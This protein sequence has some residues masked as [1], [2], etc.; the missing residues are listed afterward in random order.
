MNDVQEEEVQMKHDQD[1]GPSHQQILHSTEESP[2][3][4]VAAVPQIAGHDGKPFVYQNTVLSFVFA[5]DLV[6][7]YKELKVVDGW[8]VH[9]LILLLFKNKI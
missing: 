4:S 5:I 9:R 6:V 2:A 3:V 8:W 7:G 1:D